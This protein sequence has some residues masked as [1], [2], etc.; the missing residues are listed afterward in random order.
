MLKH[1]PHFAHGDFLGRRHFL[2]SLY[3]LVTNLLCTGTATGLI[4]GG[5]LVE[6]GAVGVCAMVSLM[7]GLS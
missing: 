5:S 3:S 1:F 7:F 4:T 6:V 2:F